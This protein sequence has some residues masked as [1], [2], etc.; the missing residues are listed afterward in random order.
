MQRFLTASSAI[1]ARVSVPERMIVRLK[2]ER[3][4]AHIPLL[5][6]LQVFVTSLSS[7]LFPARDIRINCCCSKA[8]KSDATTFLLI[9]IA[10]IRVLEA[11]SPKL[12]L[13]L[14]LFRKR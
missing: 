3:T 8:G 6:S 4:I 2:H 9:T 1:F 10:T 14:S 12:S 13:P 11:H 5:A 7:K